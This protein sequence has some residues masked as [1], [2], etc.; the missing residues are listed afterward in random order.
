VRSRIAARRRAAANLVE[1]DIVAEVDAERRWIDTAVEPHRLLPYCVE[2]DA[3]RRWP[4][5]FA[6]DSE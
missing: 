6:C 2:C 3:L 1:S 4:C 5:I